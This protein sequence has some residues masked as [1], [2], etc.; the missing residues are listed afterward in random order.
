MA[1]QMHRQSDAQIEKRGKRQHQGRVSQRA[2]PPRRAPSP[3]K[4][5]QEHD[6]GQDGGILL[7]KDPHRL[8]GHHGRHPQQ[9]APPGGGGAFHVTQ[10][11]CQ[12]AE[13]CQQVGAA[14]DIGDGF[15][16]QRMQPPE[17]CQ[18]KGRRRRGL[19]HQYA[20][21]VH[22]RN[23]HRVQRE[24]HPMIAGRMRPIAEDG[25]IQQVGEGGERAIQARKRCCRANTLRSE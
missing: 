18:R 24:I 15:G 2:P 17:R 11:A 7:G 10:Q 5:V 16:E 9:F 6:A 8:G 20:Q 23:I 25:V 13:G 1:S 19:K 22:E 3:R 4:V 21:Q 14:H 12:N